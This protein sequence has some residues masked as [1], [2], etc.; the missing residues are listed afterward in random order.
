MRPRWKL[1]RSASVTVAIAFTVAFAF[2]AMWA[3]RGT[4]SVKAAEAPVGAAVV[5][6]ESVTLSDEQAKAVKVAVVAER[7]FVPRHETEGLIDFNQDHS[8]QVFSPWPGRI[9]HVP[10]KAGDDVRQGD[11]LFTIE[12]PDLIAAE[13]GLITA[14]GVLQLTTRSL[15]RA[16]AMFESQTIAQKDL[17]QAAS[18]QQTAQANLEAARAAVRIFGKSDAEIER[19]IASRSTAAELRITSPIA[20]RVTVRNAAPGLL[21]QPGGGPAP[22]TVADLSTM[23][24]VANV[25]EDELP[26]VRLGQSVE[27][28]LSAYPDRKFEGRVSNIGAA[29]D[30]NTHRVTVRSE[31][32]DPLHELRSQMLGTFVIHTGTAQRSPAAPLAGVV[33]EGDGTMEVFVT[34]DG[35]RFVRR[36]VKLGLQQ[37]GVDQV[38]DGLAK[39]EQIATDNALFVANELARQTR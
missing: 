18:D 11:L 15:E 10:A 9:A 8:V 12:S 28:S 5:D 19:I 31:I 16:R 34:S 2:Y 33:R 13:S 6:G 20:G 37:D 38:L 24:M 30:P 3:G 7:D 36:P 17:D 39:G 26:R 27:V 4:G 23:W 1:T 29:V 35:R 22:F 14:A 25:A 21:V 32:R